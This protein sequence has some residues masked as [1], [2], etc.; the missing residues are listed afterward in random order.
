MQWDCQENF[1]AQV[2]LRIAVRHPEFFQNL[3][4]SPV[5]CLYIPPALGTEMDLR[6]H[7]ADV[8]VTG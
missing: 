6:F 8:I 4:S 5:N 2:L 7:S 3:L 1:P